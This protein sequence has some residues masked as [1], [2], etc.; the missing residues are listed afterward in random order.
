M[1]KRRF[2]LFCV[3]CG[4]E[5]VSWSRSAREQFWLCFEQPCPFCIRGI[6]FRI[7]WLEEAA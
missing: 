4:K 7:V 3:A 5:F 6:V 2:R 1:R